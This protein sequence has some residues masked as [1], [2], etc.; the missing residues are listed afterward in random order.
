MTVPTTETPPDVTPQ[1]PAAPV[2]P[3]PAEAQNTEHMIPQARFNEVNNAKKKAEDALER[4]KKAN[5]TAEDDAL[6]E[7][8]KYEDLYKNAIAEK[9]VAVARVQEQQIRNAFLIEAQKQLVSNPLDAYALA[10]RSNITIDDGNITGVSEAV[11]AL[12]TANRLPLTGSTAPPP[13]DGG[14]GGTQIPSKLPDI[15]E[16]EANIAELSGIPL[17]E[18]K[19]QKALRQPLWANQ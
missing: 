8:G 5:K 12:V 7:Q 6:A 3:T 15:S 13:L 19:K 14:A 9:D 17:E 4:L 1:A 2:S 16:V 11:A 18:Y 10:D